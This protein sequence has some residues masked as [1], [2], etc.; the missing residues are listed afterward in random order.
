MKHILKLGVILVL[1]AV[2]ECPVTLAAKDE[3][4]KVIEL[5]RFI[6]QEIKAAEGYNKKIIRMMAPLKFQAKMKRFPEEKPMAYVYTAMMAA[7]VNP[8]PEADFRMFVESAEGRIIPVYVEKQTVEKLK[9]GLKEEQPAQFLG[10]HIY[11]YAK[12]PAILV[13]DFLSGQ[14]TER[15]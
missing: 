8:M 5:D 14:T 7:G 3:Q 13:V 11:T 2:L 15:Q 10:Y 4:F 9:S 12:G 1:L 6:E